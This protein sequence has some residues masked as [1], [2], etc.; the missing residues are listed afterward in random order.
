[1]NDNLKNIIKKLVK[2]EVD[3]LLERKRAK[4]VI[5]YHGTSS[6][7]L[8]KIYQLGMIP[9][10]TEGRWKGEE[11]LEASS[12]LSPSMHSLKG[13]YWTDNIV[14]AY[15]SARDA[16]S[17][18]GESRMMIVV[19][20]LVPQSAKA[21]EDDVRMPVQRAFAEALRSHFGARDLDLA[22]PMAKGTIDADPNFYKELMSDFATNLH[23]KLKT[24]EKMPMDKAMMQDTF[25]AA[26]ERVLGHVDMKKGRAKQAYIESYEYALE[27]KMDWEKARE[28]A[29]EMYQKNEI[30]T[31]NVIEGEKKFLQA[32]DKLSQR[33]RKFALPP[34]EDEWRLQTTLRITE[35]VGFSGR[36]KIVAIVLG[37]G[38]V[39]ELVYGN[40]PQQFISD[41]SKFWSPNFKVVDKRSGK[42]VHNS[43]NESQARFDRH[44]QEKM[45]L[46]NY[47]KY[48]E[49]VADAYDE[50]PDYDPE[51]VASYKALISHIEKMYQ[52]MLSKVKVE[53]VP[54]QPYNSQ[55]EMSEEVKKT[56]V[57][58]ISTDYNQ[59][60]V[61][62]PEQNLKFRAVHDYIV[63]ILANVDFSDKGEVAAFNAHA[64]LLPKKAIPAAFTEIVGQAC[65]ANARGS[66]P[67]QKIALMPGFDLRDVGQVKG[68]DI[69]KKKLV[70]KPN[71]LE[72]EEGS[73][74]R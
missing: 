63:H 26:M 39:L 51:A 5:M 43:L 27:Q 73:G 69:E 12:I 62:T 9:D 22:V 6:K 40:L 23:N 74:I 49:L 8:P 35:P 61:F 56:G 1:V 54:G 59:H 64:K 44:L 48:C 38:Q 72:A 58:K 30:P 57:L 28:I 50:L 66:F 70:R 24:S 21:D 29:Q 10:P 53:F 17:T 55:K 11:E 47:K 65:Y 42:V 68:H 3:F 71:E 60:D 19:A 25:D 52:R 67:K 18:G 13:S 4:P 2:E 37:R 16:M 32:L 15:S 34:K 36:N 33:Y 14:T 20:Q 41:Y 7:H 31:F 46:S 45:V